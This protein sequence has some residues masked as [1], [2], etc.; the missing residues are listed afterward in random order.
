MS[1]FPLLPLLLSFST[2]L[3]SACLQDKCS[4]QPF[5]DNDAECMPDMT[6][7]PDLSTPTDMTSIPDLLAKSWTADMGYS[8]QFVMDGTTKIVDSVGVVSIGKSMPIS[9]IQIGV[10][11]VDHNA[12]AMDV[13][14]GSVDGL[15]KWILTKNTSER[16]DKGQIGG[17]SFS[18]A[19]VTY[20]AKND[21][22]KS[23]MFFAPW[24]L[25]DVPVAISVKD[26]GQYSSLSSD[27]DG[28]IHAVIN[29]NGNQSS[30]LASRS[31]VFYADNLIKSQV[32][33]PE[34]RRVLVGNLDRDQEPELITWDKS[35][36]KP[37][38]FKYDGNAFVEKNGN[39]PNLGVCG[40]IICPV[41]LGDLNQDG[42]SDLIVA[43]NSSIKI[44]Y[45]SG[46]ID[47]PFPMVPQ[48]IT[49][50]AETPV[51]AIAVSIPNG[52]DPPKLVWATSSYDSKSMKNTIKI[53]VLKNS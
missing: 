30:L 22:G 14:V 32:G 27:V 29:T 46:S 40:G 16:I 12:D 36:M 49:V 31:S 41:A 42:L 44:Y 24:F 21:A 39:V 15:G 25:V 9:K 43:D 48:S 7:M 38:L 45:A 52:D 10:M 37:L 34:R 8:V 47:N 23:A 17:A 2:T 19:G 3:Q 26:S 6:I 13:V 53:T 5:K 51:Q 1:R 28:R 50:P 35:G 11:M 33:S 4:V 20:F 18:R